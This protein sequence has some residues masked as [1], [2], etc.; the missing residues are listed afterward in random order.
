MLFLDDAKNPNFSDTD[1]QLAAYAAALR[2]LTARRIEEIDVSYELTRTSTH[3]EVSPVEQVIHNAV[4]I[5]C[6]HRVP[7]GIETHLWKSLS[8]HERFY[9]KG[10]EMEGHGE[11]RNGVYQELARGFGVQE[12][13]SLLANTKA[14]QTRLKTASEFGRKEL[15][16]DG[17]ARTIV[18]QAL[19]GAFKTGETDSPR[20]AITWFRSEVADY[21]AQRQRLIDIL[22]FLST[23]GKNSSLQHWHRDA[24][25]AAVLAGALRNR[26]DNV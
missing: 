13:Q 14:N 25:A 12:Y 9:L 19:F 26:Q 24:E 22:E 17:F 23:L 18:R 2:V 10:I 3:G 21:A 7:R 8:A 11:S 5:A 4:R 15:S 6:D 20:D 1:Y 16:G